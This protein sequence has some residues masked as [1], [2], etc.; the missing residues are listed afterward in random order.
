MPELTYYE[1]K[2]VEK[3]TKLVRY[4]TNIFILRNIAQMCKLLVMDGGGP[5]SPGF[6]AP[7]N[8]ALHLCINSCSLF[9]KH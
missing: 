8:S 6:L 4:E 3:L 2:L 1:R 7:L 9:L 5:R